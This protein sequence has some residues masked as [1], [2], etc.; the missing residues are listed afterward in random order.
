MSR[1]YYEFYRKT[2][3]EVNSHL[4]YNLD[5]CAS[6]GSAASNFAA[7]MNNM[8]AHPYKNWSKDRLTNLKPSILYSEFGS[9]NTYVPNSNLYGVNS[10]GQVFNSSG[11]VA[12]C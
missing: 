10:D 6:D 4:S 12:F 5:N 7:F 11:Y 8:V 3:Y 9:V 2:D 1:I